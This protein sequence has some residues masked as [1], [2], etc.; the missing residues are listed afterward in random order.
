MSASALTLGTGAEA[1]KTA[2][3]I[4]PGFC[5]EDGYKSPLGHINH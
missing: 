2:V 4:Q 5:G 1:G 3:A